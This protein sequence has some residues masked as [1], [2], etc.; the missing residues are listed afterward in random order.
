MKVQRVIY[1]IG[2]GERI[3]LDLRLSGT[4]MRKRCC[5][6]LSS[7]QAFCPEFHLFRHCEAKVKDTQCSSV[8]SRRIKWTV[9]WQIF[10]FIKMNSLGFTGQINTVPEQLA[11]ISKNINC[12]Y[13]ICNLP[14][15]YCELQLNKWMITEVIR[16]VEINT[17]KF[18]EH[19]VWK[20]PW[21]PKETSVSR[22]A[23]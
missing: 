7:Y 20:I 17:V 21:F 15:T 13:V 1:K 8:S 9:N 2:A 12:W 19:L 23:V 18:K 3:D 14:H 11:S 22:E 5:I 6:I 4:F 10:F 16:K